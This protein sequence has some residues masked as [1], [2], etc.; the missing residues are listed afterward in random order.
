ML[1][2]II[3][4]CRLKAIHTLLSPT[5]ETYWRNITRTYSKRFS[6][7]LPEVRKMDPLEVILDVLEDNNEDIDPL[8]YLDDFLDQIYTAENPDYSIKKEEDLDVFIKAAEKREAGRIK[9]PE[10]TVKKSGS[11]DFSG[12]NT[13]KEG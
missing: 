3:E 8:D 2:E 7:P 1:Q 13:D 10:L 11:V 5:E 9:K 12:L 4:Y 6:V